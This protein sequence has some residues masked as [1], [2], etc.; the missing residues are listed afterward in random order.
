ME[1]AIETIMQR[2]SVRHYK[3]TP[4]PEDILKSIID[5]GNMAPSGCNFQSW[6]FVVVKDNDFRKKLADLALP[7][8]KKWM[9]NAPEE[10]RQVRQRI[11]EIAEDPVY[12][13]APAIIFIIGTGM[14]S[15][16]DCSMVCQNIM[17]A[18][19]SMDIGSCWV[20]FGQLVLDDGN[21]REQL[22]L[23]E[24]EKVYGPILLGYP[25]GDFPESPPKKPAVIKYL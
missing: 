10:L 25:E 13:S 2:R 7:R 9:E 4:I 5:A 15:D 12:Y 20:Y 17:L 1:N 8:Y 6:R 22:E 16:L 23:K 21:V 19:R 18:A 11:D 14:T 24:D 3:P